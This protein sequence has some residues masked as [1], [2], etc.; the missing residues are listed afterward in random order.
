MRRVRPYLSLIIFILILGAS[1]GL[2][3]TANAKTYEESLE[4]SDLYNQILN[5]LQTEKE[6]I[7]PLNLNP[8]ES[9]FLD[10]LDLFFSAFCLWGAML[11]LVGNKLIPFK[12]YFW[13]L[14]II[15]LSWFLLLL[16]FRGVWMA[17]DYLVIH[18]QPDLLLNVLNNF[19]F[20][21]ILTSVIVYI[22]LLARSFSL[23]FFGALGSFL[24]S[25]LIYFV[26]IFSFFSFVKVNGNKWFDLAKQ[27]L[28]LSPAVQS[29]LS[30]VNKI[31]SDHSVVSYVR[32]RVYHI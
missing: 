4:Q 12:R 24:L 29:Y 28:G 1:L 20:A 9:I 18:L 19:S 23:S 16:L 7:R 27:N 6:L 31:N 10:L 14:F 5:N 32:F 17:L 11:L 21:V 13:F 15:N 3:Q 8:T 30:D 2:I 26:I 25:H 22:W